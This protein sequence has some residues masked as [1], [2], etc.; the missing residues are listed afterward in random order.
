[1]EYTELLEILEIGTRAVSTCNNQPWRF[2]FHNQ[3]LNIFILR[4]KNFFLKLE[5]NTWIELGTL[6]EN[7]SVAAASKGYQIEYQL[8]EHCGLDEPAATVR[9]IP[10]QFPPVDLEPL[11][12]R[13]T[14][15]DPYSQQLLSKS[16]NEGILKACDVPDIKVHIL[17]ESK[18]AQCTRILNDL[19]N[20]RLGNLLLIQE[21]LPYVRV[22]EQDIETCRDLLDVRTLNLNPNT[23]SLIK[24]AKKYPQLHNFIFLCF[25]YLGI[26]PKNSL[27]KTL[28]Q[29]GALIAFSISCR[30]QENYVN[31]GRTAQR[32][33]NYLTAPKHS[34]LH[35]DQRFALAQPF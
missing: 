3:I 9:F 7:I 12:R 4:T 2:R 22:D 13:C 18:L 30:D 8:F 34:N 5:G 1:M 33:L 20:I 21:T 14:N 25:V 27:K 15:R 29:S 6:L 11:L 32:I 24:L 35:H 17:K 23:I 10:K 16:V 19:E 28:L 31:L 26:L